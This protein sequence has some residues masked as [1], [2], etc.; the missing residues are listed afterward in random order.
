MTPFEKEYEIAM[1]S[2]GME[3]D[4]IEI[5]Q[6]WMR[7]TMEKLPEDSKEFTE[8]LYKTLQLLGG[9]AYKMEGQA[10]LI[11]SHVKKLNK[12]YKGETT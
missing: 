6:S 2:L 1:V 8:G 7:A 9:I 5:N 11:Q 4:N 10:K 3:A 12:L